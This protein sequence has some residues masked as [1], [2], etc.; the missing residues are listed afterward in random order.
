[1]RNTLAQIPQAVATWSLARRRAT[2]YLAVLVA[3]GLVAVAAAITLQVHDHR[4]VD[5]AQTQARDRATQLLGDVLSYDF[6]TIDAH[7][8]D[9]LPSLG[10]DLRG[11]FD[12]VGKEVIIP[13]AKQRQ[14]VTSATVVESSVVSASEDAVTLL[15]FVNQSTTSTDSAAPKLDGS[16][17]RVGMTEQDG[18]WV[19]TEM[20]PV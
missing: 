10:G 11:Q 16:R 5:A 20:T 8:A 3:G 17:V 7:F 14:V 9:I 1:M 12:S 13:S 15:F 4:Q 19:M 2:R 18:T 6:N